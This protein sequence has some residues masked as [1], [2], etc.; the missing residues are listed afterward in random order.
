M[1]MKLRITVA[2]EDGEVLESDVVDSKIAGIDLTGEV[3]KGLARSGYLILKAREKKAKQ[4]HG[5]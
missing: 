3:A 2:T 5:L 4:N 1:K